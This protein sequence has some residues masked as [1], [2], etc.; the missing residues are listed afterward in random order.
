[1]SWGPFD[2]DSLNC[3]YEFQNFGR[4]PACLQSWLAVIRSSIRCLL[5]GIVLSPRDF[6]VLLAVGYDHFLESI[7][8]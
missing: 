2:I 1:M 6:L 4:T 7:L 3:R 5:T 8:K